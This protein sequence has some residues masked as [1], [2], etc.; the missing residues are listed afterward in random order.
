MSELQFLQPDDVDTTLGEVKVAMCLMDP[1]PSSFIK[2]TRK[3]L[4]EWVG[5]VVNSSLQQGRI[6]GCLKEAVIRPLLKK[7]SLIHRIL[8]N[9]QPISSIPFFGKVFELVMVSQ[10]R[11]RQII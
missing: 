2:A 6:P 8:N 3:Q 7:P 11:M 5:S 1:C 10:L 9:H 4:V